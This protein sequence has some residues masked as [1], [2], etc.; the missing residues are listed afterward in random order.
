[1]R[2]YGDWAP[3]SYAGAPVLSGACVVLNLEGPILSPD[4]A[5]EAAPKAGPS[6]FSTTW[7]RS[8]GLLV[9]SAANNHIMD[10][11][12]AGLAQTQQ[13]A[14]EHGAL[15]VGAG[16]TRAAA[17][18]PAFV[19]DHG[20]R[21]AIIAC[22]ERQFHAADDDRAGVAVMGPWV[23]DAIRACRAQADAVV[24]SVHAGPELSP[25]PAPTQQDLYRAWIDAGA[26]VIHGH[27]A[28]LPQGVEEYHGGLILY[29][30]GN[31]AVDP[32]DWAAYPDALWSLAV[33]VDFATQ[34]PRY[35]V[36]PIGLQRRITTTTWPIAVAHWRT[37]PYSLACTRRSLCGH[38]TSTTVPGCASH[39]R[40]DPDRARHRR[41]IIGCGITSLPAKPTPT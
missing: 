24:V 37:A 18:Q 30:L 25:W 39:R 14:H 11:G 29:G 13:A 10:Y 22:C 2:F 32:N 17:R 7:P 5:L 27:H 9:C 8:E 28:H 12:P 26:R 4:H 23:H 38:T 6:L 19:D 31:L 20:V 35:Q 15:L 21:V 41:R 40:A 16:R 1:M 34:P 3:G 36:I 33:N